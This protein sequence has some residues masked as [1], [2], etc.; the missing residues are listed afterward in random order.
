MRRLLLLAVLLLAPSTARADGCPPSQCGTATVAVPGSPLLAV[1]PAGS[2]GPAAFYDLRTSRRAF[3]LPSGLQS[4]DGRHHF[5]AR[6]APEELT[7]DHYD[8]R[9]ARRLHA[10]SLPGR[11]W[12]NAV[13]PRGRQLVFKRIQPLGRTH[14]RVTDARG[15][16]AHDIRLRGTFE[17][18]A[19]AADGR[20]LFL[21]QFLRTGYVVRAYDVRARKL[22][23]IRAGRDPALMRGAAWTAVPS[24][25]G[26]WLLT[27]YLEADGET[28]IHALDLVRGRAACIDLP[29]A[30]FDESRHYTLTVA[31]NGRTAVAANPATGVVARVDLERS[32]VE[33]VSRFDAVAERSAYGGTA[34]IGR[35]G[36]YFGYERDVWRYDL[37]TGA[38]TGPFTVRR[39]VLGIGID[40]TG[41]AV[42]IVTFGGRVTTMRT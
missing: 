39:R 14:L 9:T 4:A 17:A 3:D 21:V 27:L 2:F 35:G 29:R 34:A 11:W 5:A 25:N 8:A 33:S 38:V 26:R 37:S 15:R 7:V 18:E 19:I 22:T 6:S 23:T 40:P 36:A 20:R 16:I 13:S 41:G 28:A 10:W 31:P 24:A 12:L 42:R 30:S 32:S 1:R